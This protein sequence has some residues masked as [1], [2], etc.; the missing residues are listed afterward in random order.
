[1]AQNIFLQNVWYLRSYYLIE[2]FYIMKIILFSYFWLKILFSF[3]KI[4]VD[5]QDTYLRLGLLRGAY[6]ALYKY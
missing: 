6:G 2:I 1:M 3:G 4:T 5:D